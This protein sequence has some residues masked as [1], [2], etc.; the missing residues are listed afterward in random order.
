MLKQVDLA[1]TGTKQRATQW[2]K[3]IAEGATL[4]LVEAVMKRNPEFRRLD[5][6]LAGLAKTYLNGQAGKAPQVVGVCSTA[7]GEGKTTVAMGLATA[8]A[9]RHQSHVLLVEGDLGNA[10]L[11]KDLRKEMGP[12][13]AECLRGEADLDAVIQ[14][15]PTEN[16]FIITAGQAGDDPISMLG[17]SNL[18]ELVLI[19]RSRYPHIIV[20]MP[21]VLE[22]EEVGRLVDLVDGVIL[23]IA[24]GLVPIDVIDSG[25]A[26]IGK[27]KLMGVIL[28]RAHSASPRWLSRIFSADGALSLS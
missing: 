17:G 8:L 7:R 14:T 13:L 9:R 24:A 15:T 23:V 10:T 27:D 2:K 1:A 28:N 26:A 6:L 20:D 5:G 16:L 19:L 4:E 25:V 3:R 22:G 12:G 11:A 18:K 21:A